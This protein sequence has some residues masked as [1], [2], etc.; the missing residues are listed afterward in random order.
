[1]AKIL[2]VDDR[3]TNR[4]VLVTLLGYMGHN[5]LEAS[6]GEE[7]LRIARAE[8]PNLIIADVV[9]PTMD[10]YEFARQVRSDPAI[11]QT[12]I[13]FYTSSL[14]EAETRR[15]AQA[16]GVA[17]ILTK[18]SEPE[19]IIETVNTALEADYVQLVPPA[20]DEFHV[21]HMRLLTDTLARKVEDLEAEIMERTRAELALKVKDEELRAMTQ[22]LWQSAKL[23]TMGKLAAEIAHELNNPLTAVGLRTE[24]MQMDL[25]VDSPSRSDLDV[26]IYAVDQMRGLVNNLLQFSR[27]S[28]AKK[29]SLDMG[30]EINKALA[31]LD[32]Y[33]INHRVTVIKNI[34]PDLPVVMA[35]RQQ[36]RQVLLNLLTNA[37]DAM[38][39]GGTLTI[40][41]LAQ[42]VNWIGPCLVIEISDTGDG[43]P[44][45]LLS[46]VWDSFFTTK[47]EGKGT[48]LGLAICRG[49]MEE[50]GGTI[51]IE[52]EGAPGKG[53][54][55]R[56][57]L[58]TSLTELLEEST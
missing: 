43:I 25:P 17:Y 18:P 16:C 36:L 22:Q 1:M 56:L 26:I 20:S 19:L 15:L 57:T 50:H 54:T 7:G 39:S 46:K 31:L 10:G 42:T 34:S 6:E 4:D 37:T 33:L 14:I 24:L 8:Q 44:P 32:H 12:Q 35:D 48:G 21:R 28:Q 49:I 58:P 30:D 45:E 53:A 2:I 13:I 51:T 52:S 5:M 27:R 38:P 47:A 3:P 40:R 55:V 29:I 23:A 9:M 11:G 41:A